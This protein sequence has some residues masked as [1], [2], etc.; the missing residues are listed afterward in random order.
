MGS[1]TFETGIDLSL[2]S[3][4][5]IIETDDQFVIGCMCSLRDVEIH[6]G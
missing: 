6:P 5:Q 3:L 2:L 4:D 1:L